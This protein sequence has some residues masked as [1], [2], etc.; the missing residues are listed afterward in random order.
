MNSTLKSW[1]QNAQPTAGGILVFGEVQARRVSKT[2]RKERWRKYPNGA[3]TVGL[4][5][6]LD[7][8]F[9]NQTQITAW[10]VGLIDD[11]GYS[12]LSAADTSASHAGWTELQDY[13]GNRVAYSPGAAAGGSIT[14]SS[15]M[16]FTMTDDVDV[17]GIL[18]ASSNTKG[19]AV[20]TLWATAV[21]AAGRSIANGD[22]YQVNYTITLTP[23][24]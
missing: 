24:S 5:K 1:M 16:A 7:V 12:A 19:S 21:E 3:V 13:S 9:R 14:V 8:G 15:A 17:R 2:G 22:Q 18:V 6:L 11:S 23:T 4:N 20:D 10:Y